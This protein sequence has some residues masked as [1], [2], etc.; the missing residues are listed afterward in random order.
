MI[1]NK[2]LFI[3]DIVEKEKLE[4]C[5]HFTPGTEKAFHAESNRRGS[6]LKNYE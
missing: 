3:M 6:A 5:D 2:Y 4:I 1:G